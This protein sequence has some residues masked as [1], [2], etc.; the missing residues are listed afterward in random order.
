MTGETSDGDSGLSV[1]HVWA[2]ARVFLTEGRRSTACQ[3]GSDSLGPHLA[4]LAE[5]AVVVGTR[6]SPGPGWSAVVA[7]PD[8]APFSDGSFDLVVI[9]DAGRSGRPP[10]QVLAEAQR[11][12]APHGRVLIGL[13]SLRAARELRR[14]L[15]L[16]SSLIFAALPGPRRPAVL[17]SPHA[18]EAARYFMSRVAFPYRSPGRAGL[19]VRLEQL[20]NRTALAVPATLA[21]RGVSGRL[22]VLPS[23]ESRSSLLEDLV[24]SIRSSWKDLD[25]PGPPPDRLTPLVIGHR[26]SEAAVVSV[27]LFGGR[28]G[29]VAKL[30]RY[31]EHNPSLRREAAVLEQVLGR[32]TGPVRMTLPRSLGIH[33][34]GGTEV[35]LQTL[36]P[37]KHLVAESATRPLRRKM[38]SRQLDLMLSW[39]LDLQAASGRTTI[40]D[41]A[42]ISSTIVPLVE[43]GLAALGHEQGVEELL[44]QAL[45]RAERL[46][47]TSLRTVVVHGD[48][49]AGNVMVEQARVAGVVDWERAAIDELP[50]W[51]PVKAVI[52]TVYHLD[53][54]RTVRRRGSA[55]LPHWGE[56]GPWRGI[57]DP[58]FATGFRAAVVEPGW[59]SDMARDALVTTFVRAGIPLGWLPVAIPLH[60]VR[61]F[62]HADASPRSLAGWGSVLRALAASPGTWADD[63]ADGP[64]DRN[65]ARAQPIDTLGGTAAEK[66]ADH[67]A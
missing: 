4:G 55:G 64:S 48:Y 12:C 54:Y 52:D 33:M 67:G 10:A 25:L 46:V 37:G 32:V 45:L 51:D 21:L 7:E 24:G 31:G 28:Q 57:A 60:L 53:R 9:E 47:G 18:G 34:V 6:V 14:E 41:D 22:A 23:H 43:A 30:P 58:R 49:W 63:F 35:L 27:L 17:V 15:K 40:V 5:H 1:D 16:D 2:N 61:E 3:L 44:C 50:I 66:G 39:C 65:P 20:R 26:R 11:L 59:L 38:F 29:L 8:A 56:L 19:A 42:L 62:A 13:S 36:V